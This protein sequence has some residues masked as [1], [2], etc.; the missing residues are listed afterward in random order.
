MDDVNVRRECGT[1]R[2]FRLLTRYE[3]DH[4]EGQC[5]RYPPV[6]EMGWPELDADQWCGEYAAA[7]VSTLNGSEGASHVR[8]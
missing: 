7:P 6:V 1:C 3:R 5:R 8:A 4:H 2:Y